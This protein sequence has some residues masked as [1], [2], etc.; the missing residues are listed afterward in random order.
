[1]TGGNL[2]V[3]LLAVDGQQTLEQLIGTLRLFLGAHLSLL[4][5]PSLA[6]ILILPGNMP[7][8]IYPCDTH[9]VAVD[10]G[11]HRPLVELWSTLLHGI[12]SSCVALEGSSSLDN[13]HASLSSGL[14]LGLSC[15]LY[16]L[17]CVI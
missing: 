14:A 13:N 11:G 6:L 1:M 8:V 7:R 17:S 15:N 12:H 10:N 2:L 16:S 5:H 3:V 9:T 4:D